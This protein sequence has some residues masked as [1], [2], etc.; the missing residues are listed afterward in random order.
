VPASTIL[1]VES[2]PTFGDTVSTGLTNVGYTV[3]TYADAD[4]AFARVAE[5]QLVILD[6]VAGGK[7]AAE[8]CREIRATPALAAI[9][10]ICISQTDEVEERI[11]F[12]EAGADDVMAKPF[13]ARELEAR[14]EALLLRFQRSKDLTPATA[15]EGAVLAKPRRIVVVFSPKGGVGTTTIATNI[16]MAQAEKRPDR[17]LLADLHLQFGQAATHLN[18]E[19]RMSL[20]ELVRDDAALREP[21]LFR[22]YALRHDTGLHVLAAP[23]TPELAE[24]VEPKH[25]EQLLKTALGTYEQLV[26]DAGSVLD[27]RTMVMFEHADSIVLPVYPEIA[28][29]KAVHG[30]LDYFNEAGSLGAKTSFVL[31]NMFAREILR[32]RDV[33]SALGTKVATE[34][35]YDPF[36]YLKAVNEG[37]PVVRGAP[38]STAADR[39]VKLAAS[40]FGAD[41]QVVPVAT[42]MERRQRGLGGL[43]RRS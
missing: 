31:N 13:D 41:G 18:L 22:T 25:I 11:R 8:L 39:L 24:L 23:P 12:L 43:L 19:V 30:L 14:V 4:E 2:N 17:V 9:P 10:V 26:I 35:P 37:V 27:E 3:S 38:R 34:L 42:P 40:S 32:M 15:S 33:E 28:A 5:H 6:E 20:A 21:E 16:A 29:L 7:T 36:L 1:F